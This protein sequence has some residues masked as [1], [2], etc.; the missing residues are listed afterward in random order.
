MKTLLKTAARCSLF[1]YM[2]H[3]IANL[4]VKYSNRTYSKLK[5][6][7]SNVRNIRAS[8]IKKQEYDGLWNH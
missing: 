1:S 6:N 3:K 4:H 2:W 8:V 7:E 5:P